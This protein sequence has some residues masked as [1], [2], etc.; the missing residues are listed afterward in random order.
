MGEHDEPSEAKVADGASKPAKEGPGADAIAIERIKARPLIVTG[1]LTAMA[2]IIVGLAPVYVSWFG[3]KDQA[4]PETHAG[5][6]K[7]TGSGEHETRHIEV[8]SVEYLGGEADA[9]ARF[10]IKIEGTKGSYELS[11]PTNSTFK[12]LHGALEEKAFFT[13]PVHENE[14]RVS[15]VMFEKSKTGVLTVARTNAP[16]LVR[17]PTQTVTS[18]LYPE[19]GGILDREKERARV[20][21]SVR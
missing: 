6:S 18:V 3:K 14:Y 11:F 7:E 12:T 1:V 13:L 19:K 5:E 2:T 15:F 9:A 16:S 17:P 8:H 21:F 20:R 10:F 4:P